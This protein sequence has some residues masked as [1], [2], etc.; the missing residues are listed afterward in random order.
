[1]GGNEIMNR[2]LSHLLHVIIQKNLKSWEECLSFI[3][4]AYNRI[5]HSTIDFSSF[6]IVYGFNPLTLMNLI[7]LPLEERVSL[8]G[9]KKTKMVRELHKGVQLQ[10]KIRNKL[11]ASKANKGY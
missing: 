7:H 11:Y 1:M 6:E 4:F 10:I 3:E 8:D 9:E 2:N 5:L